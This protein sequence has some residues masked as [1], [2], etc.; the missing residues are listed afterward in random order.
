VD[1]SQH[2]YYYFVDHTRRL[3]FWVVSVN[4]K[5][6]GTDLQGTN[7]SSHIRYFLEVQYWSHCE[8]YP[9]NRTLPKGVF[10][11]LRGM[12]NY[13]KTDMMT[14]DSS[15]S[16]F[17]QDELVAILDLINSLKDDQRIS[18][19]YSIWVI[20]RL[21]ALFTENQFLK[22]H[23]QPC[24]RL[25][26]DISLFGQQ[27]WHHHPAFKVINLF[28]FGSPNEHSVRL[29]RVWVDG[30][31]IQPRWKDFASRLT[32]ELGRYTLFSTVMLAV[33]FSFLAVP[34]VT[35]P[36][37]AASAIEIIIYCSVASTTA[38][39]IFSF[40][41]LNVYNDPRLMAAG[42]A[43]EVM[44]T[45][46]QSNMGM[47]CLSIAHSLP[48]ACLVWSITLFSAALAVQIFGTKEL[49]IVATLG[50]ECF[51]LVL[52]AGVS[53][54]VLRWFSRNDVDDDEKDTSEK[55][56]EEKG[57]SQHDVERGSGR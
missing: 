33:N 17:A 13:F 3:L 10:G 16:P 42:V 22:F 38:S 56:S 2:C 49:A 4:T 51:I 12:L 57:V 15:S 35:N 6:L 50:V 36:D 11:D 48:I 18:D 8:Y 5:D 37:K 30:T 25:N 20:A 45:I 54:R 21:M 55:S 9:H 52:L 26:A 7:E 39:I 53:V 41:L 34:G 14:A 46:S 44:Q 19:P 24:A 31:I 27:T 32:T 40:A 47:A 43:A 23:G 28:L 1:D 29:Q